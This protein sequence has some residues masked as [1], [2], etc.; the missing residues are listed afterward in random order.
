MNL[1][2]NPIKLIKKLYPCIKSISFYLVSH[3]LSLSVL[4]RT[5]SKN[6]YRRKKNT[7]KIISKLPVYM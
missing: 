6:A 1:S 3:W 4:R 5:L 7:W 2:R